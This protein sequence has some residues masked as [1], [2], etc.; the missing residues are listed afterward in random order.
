MESPKTKF[1]WY[2]VLPVVFTIIC[3]W[4]NFGLFV[5]NTPPPWPN[6]LLSLGYLLSWCVYPFVFRG[7]YGRNL[8]LAVGLGTMTAAA[9]ALPIVLDVFWSTPSFA[10]IIV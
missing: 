7:T 10:V 3:S 1:P 2:W 8:F 4:A 5:F 9:L 6:I